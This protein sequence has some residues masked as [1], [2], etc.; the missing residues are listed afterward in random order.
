MQNK[1]KATFLR[2]IYPLALLYW[3]LLRPKT[4]GTKIIIKQ[5]GKILFIK[6]TYGIRDWDLPGGGIKKGETP[7]EAV[8]REVAEELNLTIVNPTFMGDFIYFGSYK[9][10]HISVFF[11]ELSQT[12]PQPDMIEVSDVAWF[13]P[14]SF[15]NI[16]YEASRRALSLLTAN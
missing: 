13:A 12:N 4:Y 14:D 1:T 8:I 16:K 5:A 11:I 10:D 6:N 2:F 3:F 7:Q 15:P 9:K